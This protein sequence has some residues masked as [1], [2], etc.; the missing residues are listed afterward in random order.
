MIKVLRDAG[1]PGEDAPT[2]ANIKSAIS[3]L[4]NGAKAGDHLVFHFSGHGGQVV[5]KD[6]DEADGFDGTQRSSWSDRGALNRLQ[7]H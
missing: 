5:D 1:K 6:G 3:W 7:R 4:A 2:L